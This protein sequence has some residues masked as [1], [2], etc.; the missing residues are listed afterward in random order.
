MNP[1]LE[2]AVLFHWAIT[3]GPA[4]AG[5]CQGLVTQCSG[6][7]AGPLQHGLAW[8]MAYF[9]QQEQNTDGK[10]KL[11]SVPG[12]AQDCKSTQPLLARAHGKRSALNSACPPELMLA[13][14]HIFPC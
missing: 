10:A 14:L 13:A 12:P 11:G 7:A 5:H 1:G 6:L 2:L 9:A 4:A 8:H 3:E